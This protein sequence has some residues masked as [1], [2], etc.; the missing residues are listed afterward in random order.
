MKIPG[1]GFIGKQVEKVIAKNGGAEKSA[2]G[3]IG[4]AGNL[5]GKAVVGGYKVG[6]NIADLAPIIILAFPSFILFHSS[7]LSPIDNLLCNTAISSF[8]NLAIN[9]SII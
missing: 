9:L 7:Y 6:A 3:I 4:K 5:V 8:L 1:L 2:L